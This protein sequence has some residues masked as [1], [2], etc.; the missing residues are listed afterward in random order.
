MEVYKVTTGTVSSNH[1]RLQ[2]DNL[3]NYSVEMVKTTMSS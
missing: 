2:S 3:T 1:R